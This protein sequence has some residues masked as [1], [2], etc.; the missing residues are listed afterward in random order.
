MRVFVFVSTAVVSWL[1]TMMKGTRGDGRTLTV[2]LMYAHTVH[3]FFCIKF[4]TS[5]IVVVVQF[6]D[7]SFVL[8]S[9]L[10]LFF[11]LCRMFC[12]YMALV[13]AMAGQLYI[14]LSL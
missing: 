9:R 14:I 2:C 8:L 4:N 3:L 10:L 13:Y 7:I 1:A 12:I 5:L 6:P 11:D